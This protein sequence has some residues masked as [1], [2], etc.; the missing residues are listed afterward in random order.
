MNYKTIIHYSLLSAILC[1]F[2]FCKTYAQQKSGDNGNGTFTNPVIQADFPDPDVILVEDTYYMVS[3]TMFIFPGVTILKSKD[4]VNWEYCNNA[5]TRFDFNDCFNLNNCDRYGHGQWAT[6]LKY[7]NNKFHLLFI[8]L[9]EGGFYLT[10]D[11][12]EGPWEIKHLEKGYYDPGLFFDDNGKIYVSHGYGDILM[13]E[14]DENMSPVSK[15]SLVFKGNIRGGLEGMHVYKI[16]NYYYLYGTYGGLDGFQVALRSKNIYGPYEQKI[17]IRDTTHGPNYGIHQGALI[18]TPIGEWWTMLF[19]DSGPFGRFPSLQPITW[20]NGWPIAGV[21]GKAVTNYQKPNVGK[22][23]P[24][25]FLPTSDEFEDTGLGMQWGWNHNP[26][27]TR[28]S[29]KKNPGQLTLETVNVTTDFRK[30]RNTLTQRMFAYFSDSIT[31]VGS[32]KLNIEKMEN[33]DVAGLAI[34]QDPYAYIGVKKTNNEYFIVMVNNN[35]LIDSMKTN[36]KNIYFKAK[37]FF[38]SGA[39]PMYDGNSV[40]GTGTATF[41]FSEDNKNY[42]RFGNMLH[43]EFNLSIF[44]GNKFCLFNYATKKTGGSVSFDYFRMNPE[45]EKYFILE[46]TD[47]KF[48]LEKSTSSKGKIDT[49]FYYSSTVGS[50]RRALIYTP[51][52]Y[53]RSKKYPVLYLLHGIGGDEQEWYRHGQPKNIL[54]NL[55]AEKKIAPMIVVMPNGRA[56]KN[57]KVSGDIFSAD[58]IA[59]FAN[60]EN[61]LLNDLIPYIEKTYSTFTNREN[62]AIAGLSMG[63]GQSLNIGLNNFNQFAWIGGFSSAPNTKKPEELIPDPKEVKKNLNLLWISCGKNDDLLNV[64]QRTNKFLIDHEIPHIYYIEPGGHDFDV[65]KND[66]YLFSQLLFKKIPDIS[67]IVLP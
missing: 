36:S 53:D 33:G 14:V 30:A 20:E 55:S 11:R 21:L 7:H 18:K 10:A 24:I 39:A 43:M 27:N 5:V 12:A 1:V 65:W 26:E 16:N 31:T 32:T 28:W 8:T 57:D 63:G 17:V 37:P 52:G 56:M 34:L 9:D 49:I 42:H 19:V 66:L 54:D 64:S 47:N 15:D 6:S 41:Y 50:Q 48:D 44:T 23:H 62:R 22:D 2:V 59:A 13:T 35:K 40:S 60:F 45:P 67:K 51:P 3:T 46:S 38:G 25:K 4:L 61:D 58:K 29:L